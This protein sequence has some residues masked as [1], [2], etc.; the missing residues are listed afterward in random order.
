[1]KRISKE[2]RH[3]IYKDALEWYLR[4][5]TEGDGRNTGI[6]FAIRVVITCSD[7]SPYEK[8]LH[9]YPEIM[10]QCPSSKKMY[11][12]GYWFPPSCTKKRISILKKAIKL[13]AP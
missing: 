5:N 8:S 11:G 6:C 2:R 7:P 3:Q 4:N 1:M 12:I 13:S 10:S 9:Y